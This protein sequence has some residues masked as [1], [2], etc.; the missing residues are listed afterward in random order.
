DVN[1][2]GV[3]DV[4]VGA[5]GLSF[6]PPGKKD[7]RGGPVPPDTPIAYV[8]WNPFG[9][10]PESATYTKQQYY[11]EPSPTHGISD[12]SNI[13]FPDSRAFVGYEGLDDGTTTTV[14]LTRSN[15][16]IE[17]LALPANVLWQI[18]SSSPFEEANVSLHYTNDEIAG[19]NEDDLV[20]MTAES[21]DGPWSPLD[22]FVL[23]DR[24]IAN[25]TTSHF[26]YFTLAGGGP[27]D[28]GDGIP[29]ETEDA[30]PNPDGL[31][32]GD[33]NGD[34]I[35]DSMQANVVS[36]PNATDGDYI[37]LSGVSGYQFTLVQ[38]LPAA[39]SP[40]GATFPFGLVQFQLTGFTPPVADVTI[41]YENPAALPLTDYYKEFGGT[42]YN[43]TAPVMPLGMGAVFSNNQTLTMQLFDYVTGFPFAPQTLGDFDGAPNVIFD[44]GG[45][46]FVSPLLATLSSFT[47]TSIP[48]GVQLAWTTTAEANNAGFNVYTYANNSLTKLNSTIIPAQG[49]DGAGSAYSFIDSAALRS[50]QSRQYFLED[51]DLNGTKT[52][53]GPVTAGNAT[54]V[55]DWNMF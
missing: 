23:G 6:F 32:F 33:G 22:T 9:P 45:P 48:G 46:A 47:A 55:Q 4:I 18:K 53:H 12:A 17:N 7:A 49:I 51:V 5:P 34:G 14:T 24:N 30:V 40:D 50:G 16:S 43:F 8:V 20:V 28:D 41:Q 39:G 13:G 26:S 29:A 31:G 3:S 25:T 11:D 37:T 52:L 44:P 21:P 10:F 2:D 1:G 42:Y 15:A 27:A 19:L 35:P 38:A 54:A 36:L